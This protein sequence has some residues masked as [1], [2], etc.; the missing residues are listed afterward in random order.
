MKHFHA[1]RATLHIPD[2][3]VNNIR[4]N[5]GENLFYALDYLRLSNVMRALWINAICINQSDIRERNY[6]VQQIADM[7]SQT[8]LVFV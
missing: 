4:F 2:A 5:I 1:L 7:H 6:Q 8:H 3:S